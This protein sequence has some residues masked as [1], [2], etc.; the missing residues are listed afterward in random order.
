M[1]RN[2]FSRRRF[3]AG[4]TVL[5]AAATL[6][7]CQK[8]P[9][10]TPAPAQAAPTSA[11]VQVA[12]TSAPA[13]GGAADPL[14]ALANG[15]GAIVTVNGQKVAV[16]KDAS[17]TVTQLSPKCTHKGCDVAWNAAESTW[18]CPCHGSRFK[19]DGSV[20]NGPAADA[21]AKAG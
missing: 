2:G 5:G 15:S 4:A 13:S 9:T 20:L 1:V 19:A 12:P 3:L 21:L 7:A 10:P 6:A 11:P 17:G 18:D 8:A 16:Y 14:G